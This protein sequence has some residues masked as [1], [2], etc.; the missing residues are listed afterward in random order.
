MANIALT[1]TPPPIVFPFATL[2]GARLPYSPVPRGRVVFR[3]NAQVIAAKIATNTTSIRVN[4]LL[5]ANYAY[6]FEW[7]QANVILATDP[8]EASQFE[9]V[10]EMQ[11]LLGDGAGARVTELCSDGVYHTTLNAGSGRAWKVVKQFPLPIYNLLQNNP[12]IEVRLNDAD[13]VNATVAGLLSTTVSCLQ[14]DI[15]QVFNVGVNYPV[16]VQ[17]R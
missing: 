11:F 3:V 16:P 14:Y 9:A 10:G 13:A 15:E 17:V 7:M 4:C 5:P 2:P 1:V 8:L 6:V 12:S